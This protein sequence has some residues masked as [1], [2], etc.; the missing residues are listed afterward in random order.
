MKASE[1]ISLVDANMDNI[2]S[3]QAKVTWINTIE[4]ELYKTN[5]EEQRS[6]MID[7]IKDK[8]I[9]DLTNEPFT[10]EDI[11]VVKI[12]GVEYAQRNLDQ[13][14]YNSFYKEGKNLVI[15]PTPNRD[16]S[17]GMEIIYRYR[18]TLKTVDGMQDEDL[19]IEFPYIDIYEY[20]LYSKICMLNDEFGKANNWVSAYNQRVDDYLLYVQKNKPMSPYYSGVNFL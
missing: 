11:K 2:Y 15:Y 1:L 19:S 4:Q 13:L 17:E 14:T 9:Y 20:Y 5:I 12:N 16:L 3:D 8:K 6:T 10:F 7:L 18:P